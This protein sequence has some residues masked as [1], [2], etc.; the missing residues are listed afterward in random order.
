MWESLLAA[1]HHD[2]LYNFFHLQLSAP[3]VARPQQSFTNRDG[4]NGS[5]RKQRVSAKVGRNEPCPCG[6]G[7]KYKKCHGR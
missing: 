6:S 1:I 5:A 2:V 4:N 3:P 7:R